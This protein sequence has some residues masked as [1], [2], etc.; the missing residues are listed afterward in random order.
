LYNHFRSQLGGFSQ[1][2]EYFYL[3]TLLRIYPKDGILYHRGTCSTMF[4]AA[5]F[6]MAGDGKQPR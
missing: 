4:I 3:K 6:I 5:L 1:N 2:W